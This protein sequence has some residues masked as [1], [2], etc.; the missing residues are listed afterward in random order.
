MMNFAPDEVETEGKIL[1]VHVDSLE[2]LR[3]RG[4]EGAEEERRACCDLE[5]TLGLSNVQAELSR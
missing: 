3:K 1:N 5:V 2:R 4:Q